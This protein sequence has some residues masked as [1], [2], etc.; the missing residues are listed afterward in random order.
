MGYATTIKN[1]LKKGYKPLEAQFASWVDYTRLKDEK[2]PMDDVDG[3]ITALQAKADAAVIVGLQQIIL[4]ELLT[5]TVDFTY[6]MLAF[7]ELEKIW[8][9]PTAQITLKIGYTAGGGEILQEL[10]YEAGVWQKIDLSE[11]AEV[12]RTIYLSGLTQTTK[13]Y[14]FKR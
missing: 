10:Q 7:R 13:F 14:F 9:N 8:I 11:F 2:V 12:D 6:P 1:W 3:L 5:K 4:P